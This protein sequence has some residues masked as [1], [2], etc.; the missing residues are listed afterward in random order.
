M[1]P[2]TAF[3]YG[4]H[5]QAYNPSA[6]A[7]RPLRRELGIDLIRACGLLD[8]PHVT[9]IV[10]RLATDAE[11]MGAHDLAYIEAVKRYGAD[12]SLAAE[13]EGK[14]WGFQDGDTI[15]QEGMHEAAAGAAGSALTGALEIH[16]G[17][18]KFQDDAVVHTLPFSAG[19]IPPP[20][21][22]RGL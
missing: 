18:L 21:Y 8:H 12:P 15:A 9:E 10:P 13:P 5:L 17:P 6:D 20:V 16:E 2:A 11:L 14:A 4:P 19:T 3:V 7:E 22:S 1:P